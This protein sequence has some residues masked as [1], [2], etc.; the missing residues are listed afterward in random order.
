MSEKSQRNKSAQPILCRDLVL[1]LIV[2][3]ALPSLTG[4]G[5]L[6]YNHKRL[7]NDE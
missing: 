2:K 1:V 6:C 5:R 4:Y 3:D 7:G